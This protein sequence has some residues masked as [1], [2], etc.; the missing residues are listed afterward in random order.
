MQALPTLS[1]VLDAR[2][3]IGGALP[4]TPLYRN[5]AAAHA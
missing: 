4:R 1:D 2:H 3:H 5:A